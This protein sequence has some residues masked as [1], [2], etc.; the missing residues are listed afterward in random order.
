M[1]AHLIPFSFRSRLVR[2]ALTCAVLLTFTGSASAQ[3]P[4]PNPGAITLTTGVDF[5]SVY[6]FR[7]IRQEAEPKFTMFAFGDVGIA[8]GPRASVNF[9]VWN[10]LHTGTSGTDTPDKKSH[11]EEDFYA[12]LNLS[13]GHGLTISPFFTS[14]TSPNDSFGTINEFAFEV[15]H[16]SRFAPYGIV[17]FELSGQADGGSDE[18]TYAELGAA[19]SWP[20][21]AKGITL[22]IPLK[23]GFS[24][25][26]YYEADEED[27]GFG[28]FD[29]GALFTVPFSSAPTKFG[30]WNLHGGVNFLA[31]GDGTKSFNVKDGEAKGSQVIASIGIGMSTDATGIRD[32]GSLIPNPES[33]LRS[34]LMA[35]CLPMGPVKGK[36]ADQAGLR[37]RLSG[38][39]DLARR[40]LIDATERGEGGR[41]ALALHAECIDT[42]IR[43]LV[44]AARDTRRCRSPYAPLVDTA[45]NRSSSIPMSTCWWCLAGRLVGRKSGSSKRSCTRYGTCTFRSD[46]MSASSRTSIASMLRTLN[47][48]SR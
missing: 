33:L 11:Y 22:G 1:E 42:I 46:T 47:I 20:L 17:A 43:E 12:M 26:D 44:E 19:P 10:S 24:L 29:I 30:T 45:A 37:L 25:G 9:G 39:L 14:Y 35:V 21:G 3:D 8:L 27:N 7:G 32:W 41:A 31:L 5:P 13:V 40:A 34:I 15:A 16:A 36:D 6:F 18:G 23:F 38:T 4:D 28:F 48:S 2:F